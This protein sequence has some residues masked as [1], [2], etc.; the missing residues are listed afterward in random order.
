[1]DVR[2][3][4]VPE[5]CYRRTRYGAR[6]HGDGSGK[7]AGKI[8]SSV[9]PEMQNN[10]NLKVL[11][12]QLMEAAHKFNNILHSI[13]LLVSV[14]AGFRAKLGLEQ[15]PLFD[16]KIVE[17]N[18]AAARLAALSKDIM[19][20]GRKEKRTYFQVTDVIYK[21]LLSFV[22]ALEEKHIKFSFTTGETIPEIYGSPSKFSDVITNLVSNAADAVGEGGG[23]SMAVHS[24]GEEVVITVRDNGV[25]ISPER[26]KDLFTPFK[27]T[28]PDGNGLGLIIVKQW[29][30]VEMGGSVRVA[31][32]VGKG[33]TFELRLPAAQRRESAR[34]EGLVG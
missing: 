9:P 2:M 18:A 4:V 20:I 10:E 7:K 29:V 22:P 12:E 32:E 16:Q 34:P 8:I 11:G 33:T 6:L 27:T 13:T 1:M 31:S 3:R 21:L 17:L 15:Q 14:L 23:I 19:R 28:K 25:G 30:E 24:E 26:L 5:G